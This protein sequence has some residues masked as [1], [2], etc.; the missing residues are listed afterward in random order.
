MSRLL[1]DIIIL[2]LKIIKAIQYSFDYI[3]YWIVL[4]FE[5]IMVM[6]LYFFNVLQL[7][8]CEKCVK[9]WCPNYYF[10]SYW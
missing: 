4:N 5:Y 8:V 2:Q 3:C 10:K 9:P 7:P 1:D 6:V